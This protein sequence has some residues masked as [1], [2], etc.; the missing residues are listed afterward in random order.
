MMSITSE[1]L[2]QIEKLKE[3]VDEKL[4][5]IKQRKDELDAMKALVENVPEDLQEIMSRSASGS[6][7][8]RT[9]GDAMSINDSAKRNREIIL[10][11]ERAIREEEAELSRLVE[12]KQLLEG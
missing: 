10:Q 11:L 3:E 6:T 2:R 9:R 4:A 5:W 7:G 1:R 12:E 8:L